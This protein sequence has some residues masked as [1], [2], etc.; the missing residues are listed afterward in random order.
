[1]VSSIDQREIIINIIC[2]NRRNTKRYRTVHCGGNGI[3]DILNRRRRNDRFY[4]FNGILGKNSVDISLLISKDLATR[5]GLCIVPHPCHL[6]CQRVTYSNM[7]THSPEDYGMLRRYFVQIFLCG[8]SSLQREIIFIPPPACHNFSWR[9]LVVRNKRSGARNN[10]LY[11][12]AP[13][14]LD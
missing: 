2:L 14:Q 11:T 6:Q 4:L 12:S 7:P 9:D 13:R 3:L 5:Y 1:M 8:M 10:I